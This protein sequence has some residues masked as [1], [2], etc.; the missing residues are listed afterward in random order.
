MLEFRV[1]WTSDVEIRE[2]KNRSY[3][4]KVHGEQKLG[5]AEEE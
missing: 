4:K 2:S 1:A 5:V 3:R